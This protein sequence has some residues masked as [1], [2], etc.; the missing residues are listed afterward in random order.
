[1]R[2]SVSLC[3]SCKA[4]EGDS[5]GGRDGGGGLMGIRVFRGCGDAGGGRVVMGGS[6]LPFFPSS[7]IWAW[8]ARPEPFTR[9]YSCS[10]SLS[11]LQSLRSVISR[12]ESNSGSCFTSPLLSV[13]LCRPVPVPD[14]RLTAP[15]PRL[16]PVPGRLASTLSPSAAPMSV[17]PIDR[18]PGYV[19]RDSL[20]GW[21]PAVP[22]APP[23]CPI[24]PLSAVPVSPGGSTEEKGWGSWERLLCN[25]L[26]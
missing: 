11:E 23:V 1:M 20:T 18:L 26:G 8:F 15:S 12:S 24:A 3:L 5:D 9:L 25:G 10:F 14:P 4:M 7:T 17:R 6:T 13:G 2:V 19:G 16:S 22:F 21:P